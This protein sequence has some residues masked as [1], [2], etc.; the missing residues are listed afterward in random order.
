MMTAGLSDTTLVITTV[1]SCLAYQN[2]IT[3]RLLWA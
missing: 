3:I 2:V 1:Q